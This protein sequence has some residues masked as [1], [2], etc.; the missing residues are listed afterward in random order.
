MYRSAVVQT[1]MCQQVYLLPV[2][3]LLRKLLITALITAVSHSSSLDTI[4]GRQAVTA[5]EQAEQ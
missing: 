2:T 3:N 5:L 1:V 4:T